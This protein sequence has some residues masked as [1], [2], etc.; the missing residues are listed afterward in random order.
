[1]PPYRWTCGSRATVCRSSATRS[2]IAEAA[3]PECRIVLLGSV[4]TDKY[5]EPLLAVFGPRLLFPAE[6]AGRGDMSRGG[7]ML[8][9]ARTGVELGYVP[10][11]EARRHGPRPPRLP[12]AGRV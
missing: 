6:F 11:A 9:A 10:A 7:L 3:G 8:R 1:M 12:R 5:V 2:V 4:A